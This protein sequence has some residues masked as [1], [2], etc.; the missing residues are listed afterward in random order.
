[1][2]LERTPTSLEVSDDFRIEIPEH[3][4]AAMD[5]KPGQKFQPIVY[6]GRLELVRIRPPEEIRGI[7]KGIDT[8]VDREEDRL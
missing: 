4:R 5:I 7:L 8:E 2:N 6:E 3:I 1:M